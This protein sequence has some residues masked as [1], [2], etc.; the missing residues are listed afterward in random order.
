MDIEICGVMANRHQLFEQC[1]RSV[2]SDQLM[3]GPDCKGIS[4]KVNVLANMDGYGKVFVDPMECTPPSTRPPEKFTIHIRRHSVMTVIKTLCHELVHVMQFRKG[5][6]YYL[7]S[8]GLTYMGIVVGENKYNN[9]MEWVAFGRER[10]L[11]QQF[12][13]ENGLTY[14]HWYICPFTE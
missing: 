5:E 9:P 4:L 2:L 12:C 1:I 8:G 3:L 11:A 14:E 13:E 6:A 10:F 7:P